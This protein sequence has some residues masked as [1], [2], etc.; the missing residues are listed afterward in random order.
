MRSTLPAAGC[1]LRLQPAARDHLYTL[2][3]HVTSR[4]P[5]AVATPRRRRRRRPRR[6]VTL[7]HGHGPSAHAEAAPPRVAL[8]LPHAT[9]KVGRSHAPHAAVR[10]QSHDVTTTAHRPPPLQKPNSAPET[11]TLLPRRDHWSPRGRPA[12][13]PTA[14]APA[15]DASQPPSSRK[16]GRKGTEAHREILRVARPAPRGVSVKVPHAPRLAPPPLPPTA[17]RVRPPPPVAA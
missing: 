16:G 1:G 6:L 10:G 2:T 14:V 8:P 11:K 7:T 9:P 5:C 12:R 13:D 15:S 3:W 4:R 17:A